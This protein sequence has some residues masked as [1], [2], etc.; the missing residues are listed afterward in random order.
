MCFNPSVVGSQARPKGPQKL[1]NYISKNFL[2]LPLL[3][4]DFVAQYQG[5]LTEG[6]LIYLLK[7]LRLT[8]TIL[9]KIRW[10]INPSSIL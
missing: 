9:N 3:L 2:Q 5:D 8:S 7:T 4:E 6:W 1:M 10:K